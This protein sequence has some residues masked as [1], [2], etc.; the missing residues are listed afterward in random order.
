MNKTKVTHQSAIACPHCGEVVSITDAIRNEL[1]QEH[2]KSNI[3]AKAALHKEKL[4]LE[5]ERLTLSDQ[6]LQMEQE[7]EGRLKIEGL[8]LAAEMKN[9]AEVET[10]LELDD[11]R[12]HAE[13]LN[14]RL[15]EAQRHELELR[16]RAREADERQKAFE[17]EL[18]RKMDEQLAEAQRAALLKAWESFEQQGTQKEKELCDLKKEI[19][20]LRRKAELGSQQVQG[21]AQEEQIEKMLLMKFKDDLIEPV[22]KGEK[23]ADIIQTVNTTSG[24]S[25]GRILWEVKQTRKW[26]DLWL[27][28]LREDVRQSNAS[29]GI[30]VTTTLPK[31]IDSFDL[32]GDVWVTSAKYAVGL[33]TALR[34]AIQAIHFMEVASTDQSEKNQLLLKYI[35]GTRFRHRV[36]AIMQ[37][38]DSMK[39]NL[40]KEKRAY[41]RIWATREIDQES[42]SS[43][44]AGFYGDLIGI[45]GSN[46]PSLNHLELPEMSSD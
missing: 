37:A 29:Y 5:A 34:E 16:R 11:L 43:N 25:V 10:K 19:Q 12:T 14:K 2:E 32:V 17:L 45:V 18:Q 35:S 40:V 42:L 36:E 21:E 30:I 1:Q 4:K 33:A 13:E 41:A 28:K 23:G 7:I 39:V 24:K 44:L 26:S 6:K 38:I 31:G 20:N 27:D 15:I 46:L 22:A 9:K 3:E 8:R